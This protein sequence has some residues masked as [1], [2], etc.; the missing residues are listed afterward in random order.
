MPQK[1]TQTLFEA[2][3]AQDEAAIEAVLE[4]I[5]TLAVQGHLDV[6]DI[7]DILASHDILPGGGFHDWIYQEL[8]RQLAKQNVELP[9]AIS[10]Q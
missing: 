2:I 7:T 4:Q 1:P 5:V 10:Q 9:K 3:E 8:S 6:E